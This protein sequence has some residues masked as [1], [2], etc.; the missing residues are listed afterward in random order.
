V[1]VGDLPPRLLLR[2]L[3]YI[4]EEVSAGHLDLDSKEIERADV[5]LAGGTDEE[6]VND[7]GR[8]ARDAIRIRLVL[9]IG[10]DVDERRPILPYE[11]PV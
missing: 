2:G 6:H 8:P 7:P 11:M 4:R 5:L 9:H 3:P 10:R 1:P